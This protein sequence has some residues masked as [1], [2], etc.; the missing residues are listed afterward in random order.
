[1]FLDASVLVAI[2]AGEVE[3]PAIGLAL[4][5]CDRL[6]TSPL[7]VF[8]ASAR[9]AKLRGMPIDAVYQAIVEFLATVGVETQTIGMEIGRE[10]HLCAA[11]YHHL[12]GHPARLNMGDCF[13]YA[14]ARSSGLKLAYKGNDFIHTDVDGVRFGP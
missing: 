1:M 14:S 4:I 7:A 3:G 11:R 2:M 8:E 6:A 13:A 5:D 12:V 10:A 9:L